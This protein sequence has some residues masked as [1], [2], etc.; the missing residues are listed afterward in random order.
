MLR[1]TRRYITGLLHVAVELRCVDAVEESLAVVER[2]LKQQPQAAQFLFHPTIPRQSKKKLLQAIIGDAA[3]GLVHRFAGYVIDK[4]R[5]RILPWCH[6][7]YKLA[8]DSLRGIM[9]GKVTSSA[10]LTGAQTERLRT[11]LSRTV[12]KQVVLDFEVDPKLLGGMQVFIGSYIV[13]GS[14][15]GRLNRMYRHLLERSRQARQA[16]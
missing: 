4:K 6:K 2:A 15:T 10:G 11:D 13:D 3:P 8:A 14:L 9:R 16:A 7:E 12:G 1:V 5:E